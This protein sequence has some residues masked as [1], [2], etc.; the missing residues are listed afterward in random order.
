ML[1]SSYLFYTRLRLDA[2]EKGLLNKGSVELLLIISRSL[3]YDYLMSEAHLH[4]TLPVEE[5]GLT[6]FEPVTNR[7]IPPRLVW[8]ALVQVALSELHNTGEELSPRTIRAYLRSSPGQRW[9]SHARID[10][11]F[12]E[13]LHGDFERAADRAR[14][15][16]QSIILPPSPI[17]PRRSKHPKTHIDLAIGPTPLRSPQPHQVT[18]TRIHVPRPDIWTPQ[19]TTYP[20]ATLLGE[21]T[22]ARL[23]EGFPGIDAVIREARETPPSEIIS[24]DLLVTKKQLDAAIEQDPSIPF[25]LFEGDSV[26]TQID[27]QRVTAGLTPHEMLI[28]QRLIERASR[29]LYLPED[30]TDTGLNPHQVSSALGAL[31]RTLNGEPERIIR[32]K[33]RH[34]WQQ[35]P[36]RSAW[37]KKQRYCFGFANRT[38]IGG[39]FESVN[40]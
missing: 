21:G 25:L 28:L 19:Q 30:L 14:E 12:A 11:A 34:V 31:R 6:A 20:F 23:V 10:D 35:Q 4:H 26:I 36:D 18:D 39:Y 40:V 3:G 27:G 22:V 15:I 8:S 16:A 38:V 24:S 5:L 32:R 29:Q 2:N 7:V 9:Y 33:K 1:L 13:C 37:T 17:W